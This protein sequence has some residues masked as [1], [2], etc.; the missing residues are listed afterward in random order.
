[1]E[2]GHDEETDDDGDDADEFY[3]VVRGEAA[4]EVVGDG[5]IK[6]SDSGADGDDEEAEEEPAET[7]IPIHVL[8]IYQRRGKG[9]NKG[10]EGKRGLILGRE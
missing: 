5:A 1:M 6:V 8:I 2:V 4:G 10:D 3:A 7:K 9:K